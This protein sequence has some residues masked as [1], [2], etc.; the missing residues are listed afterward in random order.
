[1]PSR[2]TRTL[3]S[4]KDSGRYPHQALAPHLSDGHAVS[5]V[6]TGRMLT[7]NECKHP[8]WRACRRAGLRIIGWH[9]LCH[10]F[11]SH[12]VMRGAP[13][14]AVQKLLGHSY[15]RMTMRY[16]HLSPGVRRAAVALG[17]VRNFLDGP[18]GGG[19]GNRTRLGFGF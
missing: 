15:I 10:T 9:A 17:S 19:G 7:E 5:C 6:A 8:L 13:L 11:A 12:P 18:A 2:H 16:S 14:K 1:M 3:S 4:C